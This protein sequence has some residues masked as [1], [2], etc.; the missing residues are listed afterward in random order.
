VTNQKRL[1]K[2]YAPTPLLVVVV[3]HRVVWKKGAWLRAV[4]EF[5]MCLLTE[6]L[7]IYVSGNRDPFHKLLRISHERER[8]RTKEDYVLRQEPKPAMIVP[9]NNCFGPIPLE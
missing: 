8:D 3:P 7:V 6:V 5:M 1:L 9:P 4:E 2:F